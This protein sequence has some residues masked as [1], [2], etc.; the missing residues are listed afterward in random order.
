MADE[1]EQL[2]EAITDRLFTNGMGEKARRLVI[3]LEDGREGGDW[4]RS[5]VRDQILDAL[6]GR[7][8]QEILCGQMLKE[9][10]SRY[11]RYICIEQVSPP[12]AYARTCTASGLIAKG[13]PRTRI[14]L[15]NLR[16]RFQPV[17]AQKASISSTEGGATSLARGR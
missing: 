17:T 12:F 10:D 6:R 5:A 8:K 11:T 9:R 13:S 16:Q 7:S 3:E 1:L 15:D 4:C 14:K 2:A